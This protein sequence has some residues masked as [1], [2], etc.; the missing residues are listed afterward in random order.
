MRS[1]TRNNS[2]ERITKAT[3][4]LQKFWWFSWYIII[5]PL[6]IA[7]IGFIIFSLFQAGF[8]IALSFSVIT[9]M[10]ALLFF[11]KAYDKYRENPFFL[12][13]KNNLNARI[14]IIF[15]ISILSFIV[16][17]IFTLISPIGLSFSL[18]PLISYVVLY[19]IV[20]YY[21]H[22]QPIDFFNLTEEEFKHTA[23]KK[24][25][26]KQPYNFIVVVN[27]IIHIIFLTVTAPT[28]F[29]WLYALITNL[30]IYLITLASTR[31]LIKK[32]KDFIA[33]K[34]PF[35]KELTFFK[36]RY[37]VFLV[38]LFFIILIQ[39][40]Y[41]I[42][43]TFSLSGIQYST[44]ELLN[45]SFLTVIFILFYFKSRFYINSHYT[46]KISLYENP[47]TS[48]DLKEKIQLPYNKYQKYNSFLSGS[49]ILLIILY[50]FLSGNP[51]L[52][53]IILPFL[54]ILFQYE[55]KTE[56]CPKKYNRFVFLLNSIAI[57]ISISFGIIPSI[58][59]FFLLNFLIFSL[60]LYFVLQ[61]FVKFKFFIKENILIFQNI[62]AV[63][64]FS[65]FIYLFF[66]VIIIEYTT[67]TSDLFIILISNFLIHLS[68]FLVILL[69]SFY[70]L[71]ARVFH[72]KRTRL[73]RISVIINL[74]LIEVVLFILI[75]LRI[76]FLFDIFTFIQVL[77]I[78]T[79]LF[80]AL[81][82]LF[83]GINFLLG[84]LPKKDLLIIAYYSI[85]L[86]ILTI[87]L[88]IFFNNI[89]NYAIIVFDLL[90]LSIFLHFNLKFG[91]KIEKL[92]I[93]TFEKFVKINSYILT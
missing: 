20:Y 85:W 68:L 38:S 46:S 65:F 69:V 82:I 92:K 23:N 7:F 40:P 12:N 81:F 78:T 39:M 83:V 75:N 30:L 6:I 53:L 36:Q 42:I 71:Y 80:P 87:F 28:N 74:L 90:L 25:K 33:E 79:I 72:A 58:P 89:Y 84:I 63:A 3:E 66:P 10:F 21:Y 4:A 45:N 49:L 56:L 62:V 11:Y 91:L 2:Q 15:L 52:I 76:F 29:S 27:Y 17:P 64:S 59:G 9:F 70:V 77:V 32:I 16:T 54:F 88:S 44:I 50:S 93:S 14:H 73:F 26:V 24:L 31:N 5:A 47:Q 86:L 55:Q 41:V 48:E 8:Y 51:T 34:K 37:T 19:N 43:I 22:F 13:K 57:L 67:F 61:I 60:S 18:L 35:L 1:K